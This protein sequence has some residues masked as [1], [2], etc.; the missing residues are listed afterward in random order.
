MRYA[1][2]IERAEGTWAAHVPDL[3][4]CEAAGATPTEARERVRQALRL[5]VAGLQEDGDPVP[6]P[7]AVADY[8]EV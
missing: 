3:P 1:V 5:H 8:V 6:Q 4:G 7:T 2:L